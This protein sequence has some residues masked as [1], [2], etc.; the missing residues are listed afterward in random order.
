[1]ANY[2]DDPNDPNNYVI[3]TK[4]KLLGIRKACEE[5]KQIT[6]N[7]IHPGGICYVLSKII[8]LSPIIDNYIKIR[9]LK[10]ENGIKMFEVENKA[11]SNKR[12][13]KLI[14]GK[15]PGF[16][17]SEES[18]DIQVL[19][20]YLKEEI[21]EVHLELINKIKNA[22]NNN[23]DINFDNL[24]SNDQQILKK[25]F[26]HISKSFSE[27]EKYQKKNLNGGVV[28][29]SDKNKFLKQLILDDKNFNYIVDNIPGF[30]ISSGGSPKNV[31]SILIGRPSK[32]LSFEDFK[33]KKE[34]L[35]EIIEELFE[36]NLN[37][38]NSL[39][40]ST[41]G[42]AYAIKQIIKTVNKKFFVIQNP[43]GH[44]H[45]DNIDSTETDNDLKGTEYSDFN[46]NDNYKK[47]GLILL[48]I[49]DIQKK[50][51]YMSSIDLEIGKYIYQ[52]EISKEDLNIKDEKEF[53][54]LIDMKKKE[55]I[56]IDVTN[57]NTDLQNLNNDES[58]I[59][60]I[61][62]YDKNE[63]SI[64]RILPKD[65][66]DISDKNILSKLKEEKYLIRIKVK[67]P[68]RINIIRNFSDNK[69]KYLGEIKENNV[70]YLKNGNKINY[71]NEDDKKNNNIFEEEIKQTTQIMRFLEKCYGEDCISSFQEINK[72]KIILNS[73]SII[74]DIVLLKVVNDIKNKIIKGFDEK[75]GQEI[76]K[77]ENNKISFI[78]ENFKN[79][80]IDVFSNQEILPDENKI[81]IITEE[82]NYKY[83]NIKE[84]NKFKG[85]I[86]KFFVPS[87][88]LS[89]LFNK[90]E[91]R[92]PEQITFINHIFDNKED[93]IQ[94]MQNISENSAG[95]LKKM[96]T[97]GVE[98]EEPKIFKNFIENFFCNKEHIIAFKCE[99]NAINDI[100]GVLSK[101]LNK[102]VKI[103]SL[104][105]VWETILDELM[106]GYLIGNCLPFISL[107]FN[108]DALLYSVMNQNYKYTIVGHVLT[109][110]DFHLKGYTNG[111]YFEES[112]IHYWYE[113]KSKYFKNSNYE[114][115]NELF[116][117]AINLYKYVY[118]NKIDMDY[119]TIG[120]LYE[121][122][123][124]NEKEKE[125]YY[126]STYRIIGNMSE[127]K[128]LK[129]DENILYPEFNF[130]VDGDLDPLPSLTSMLN[131]NPEN[132]YK[133]D[134]TKKAH[135]QMKEKIK[136]ILI[137]YHF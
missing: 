114:C 127:D 66:S 92:T 14:V 5:I 133:W 80:F 131:K 112:F 22:K 70:N 29:I 64:K 101:I 132:A 38:L 24:P 58:C 130:K 37:E 126:I 121:D 20:E 6:E 63:K 110:I 86:K 46:L 40:I 54:F 31:S 36:K 35:N 88:S 34:K 118:N 90:D 25:I 77:I 43:S 111:A 69:I 59:S 49:N 3:F 21:R 120:S 18:L 75:I 8:S 117:K 122:M 4:G 28:D 52:Q 93:A 42:H 51:K 104:Q 30:I 95:L 55:D 12:I 83:I 7:Q 123:L 68:C 113:Y 137:N 23:T 98:F 32:F 13:I 82:G 73:K 87:F 106:N 103:N 102:D 65:L 115:E 11:K 100:K 78:D 17:K 74:K 107:H 39:T 45:N 91:E 84:I 60:H 72:D 135:E 94:K 79:S 41:Q 124:L 109:F 81:G 62:V 10:P 96:S 71:S 67:K 56:K 50:F 1:M 76:I 125:Q 108:E 134:L 19:L 128:I 9:E 53:D 16:P 85:K 61:H 129:F 116:P 33:G 48:N 15:K 136:K 119:C 2:E 44:G 26:I 47:T 57:F 105:E 89:N 27:Y 97:G 99:K